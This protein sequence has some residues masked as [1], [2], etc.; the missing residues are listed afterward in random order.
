MVNYA[1]NT[2]ICTEAELR[3]VGGSDQYQGRVE[4]CS[5]TGVWGTV[6]DD[7]WDTHDARVVCRQM[8]FS[9]TGMQ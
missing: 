5:S 1:D 4:V 3:L 6:C 9:T 2:A 7:Y 8:G